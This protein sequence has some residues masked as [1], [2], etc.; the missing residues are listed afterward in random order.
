MHI[1]KPGMAVIDLG[2]APGS[3]LQVLT[4]AVGEGGRVLG[5]D[6]QEVKKFAQKNVTTYVGDMTTPETHEVM[7]QYLKGMGLK[8]CDLITSDVAPRTTGR[9]DDDQYHSAMLC[10]E[11]V[12]IAEKF[13]V[14]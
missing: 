3:W 5:I 1:I 4:N 11:V 10:L 6:L 8:N 13:L 9:N 2:C 12:K 14:P 7:R